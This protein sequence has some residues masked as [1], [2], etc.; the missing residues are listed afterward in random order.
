MGNH[1]FELEIYP[2]SLSLAPL[3]SFSSE[4]LRI[5]IGNFISFSRLAPS[6]FG[7]K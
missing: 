2:G 5:E 1:L 4:D 3:R 6:L 7:S